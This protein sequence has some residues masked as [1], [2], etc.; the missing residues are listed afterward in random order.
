MTLNCANGLSTMGAEAAGPRTTLAAL[1]FTR[2]PGSW[3]RLEHNQ[4]RHENCKNDI[5]NT[6]CTRAL[7]GKTP[8][9]PLRNMVKGP[10]GVPG[11]AY[12]V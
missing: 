3:V 1:P 9:L 11:P 12:D 6:I 4:S 8:E 10:P 2:L 5:G 7:G